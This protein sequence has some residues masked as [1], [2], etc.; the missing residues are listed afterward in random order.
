MTH[1]QAPSVSG[2]IILRTEPPLKQKLARPQFDGR[3]FRAAGE[4]DKFLRVV[5]HVEQLQ[6]TA[7]FVQD[8]LMLIGTDHGQVV[9]LS[10][11]ALSATSAGLPGFEEEYAERNVVG[12]VKTPPNPAAYRSFL[13]TDHL[14]E[15][16]NVAGA[17]REAV[18][19]TLEAMQGS[20]TGELHYERMYP[21]TVLQFARLD[22]GRWVF[23]TIRQPR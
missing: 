16:V 5:G 18:R 17:D 21:T 22:A 10:G 11:P 13:A 20:A 3:A 2:L 1:D 14:L 12:R 6:C 7:L 9:A 4:V 23:Q 19:E 8:E 15:A